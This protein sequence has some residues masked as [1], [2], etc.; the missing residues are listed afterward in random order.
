[1]GRGGVGN[2]SGG[3][4]QPQINLLLQV[5]LTPE[6]Q[7]ASSHWKGW[8][9]KVVHLIQVAADRFIKLKVG[10][11][12]TQNMPKHATRREG[13]RRRKNNDTILLFTIKSS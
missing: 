7:V 3:K 10:E 6:Q 8:K 9:S 2:T 5:L 12:L 4:E 13:W 11:G 1:M